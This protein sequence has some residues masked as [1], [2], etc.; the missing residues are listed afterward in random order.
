MKYII[1]SILI[2]FILGCNSQKQELKE[3]ISL[4]H[5]KEINFPKELNDQIIKN[6]PE[7]RQQYKILNYIDTNGCSMCRLKLYEW[8]LLKRELDSLQ[9]NFPI[10]F[11]AYLKDYHNLK[12]MQKINKFPIPIIQDSTGIMNKANNF[13]R[14]P[15]LQTFLLDNNNKVL[16]MGNPINNQQL[17]KLYKQEIKKNLYNE[18]TP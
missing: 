16:I 3:T 9:I 2:S 13:P 4:W 7:Y 8:K 12:A 18:K 6:N 15:L 17:L 14:N 1:Y 10:I 5:Q 11:I